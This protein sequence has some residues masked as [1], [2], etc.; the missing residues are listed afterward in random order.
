MNRYQ[1]TGNYL[2]WTEGE[3][4]DYRWVAF[5]RV[6]KDFDFLEMVE[7]WASHIG[8]EFDEEFEQ[9]G[10]DFLTFVIYSK[11]MYDIRDGK[12]NDSIMFFPYL[13]RKGYIEEVDVQEGRTSGYGDFELTVK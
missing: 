8:I 5:Y 3:Y 7:E 10:H 4:S 2:V 6:L 1:K 11:K 12:Y 13:F 9:G